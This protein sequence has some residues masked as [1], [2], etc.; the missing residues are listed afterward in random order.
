MGQVS[1][2]SVCAVAI[3]VQHNTAAYRHA[4]A[5]LPRSCNA[6]ELLVGL[7]RLPQLLDFAVIGG[8]L[9]EQGFPAVI[10]GSILLR[11][12]QPCTQAGHLQITACFWCCILSIS[13]S[14]CMRSG[15]L[16]NV[17]SNDISNRQRE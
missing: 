7:K 15:S 4:H 11:L 14:L 9:V 5:C 6:P 8:G 16:S 13:N 12:P 3:I 17:A 2:V 10:Q 1:C